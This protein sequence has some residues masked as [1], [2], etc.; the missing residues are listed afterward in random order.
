[1]VCMAMGLVIL[2]EESGSVA[3]QT[4]VKV[5]RKSNTAWTKGQENCPTYAKPKIGL[6]C[7]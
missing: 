7:Q 2:L 1:M 5:E 6:D 4:K 3:K